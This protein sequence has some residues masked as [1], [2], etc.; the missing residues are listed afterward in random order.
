[1][2][3]NVANAGFNHVK[4]CENLSDINDND[5]AVSVSKHLVK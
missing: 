4:E 3:E 1:M 5:A 2:E